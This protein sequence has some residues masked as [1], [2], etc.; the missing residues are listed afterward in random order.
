VTPA[1][2]VAG[3]APLHRAGG[4]GRRHRGRC[5]LAIPPGTSLSNTLVRAG[6]VLERIARLIFAKL[7]MTPTATS[8]ELEIRMD[9]DRATLQSPFSTSVAVMMRVAVPT[10][11]ASRRA[12]EVLR[13]ERLTLA[14]SRSAPETRP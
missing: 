11:V 13:R 9:A 1:C 6:L 12:F 8:D 7:T 3:P 2:G 5:W 10:K 4:A 14:G